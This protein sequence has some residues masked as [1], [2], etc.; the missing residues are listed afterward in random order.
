MHHLYLQSKHASLVITTY[1][2]R[3]LQSEH[4]LFATS[5][6]INRIYN[7]NM[8]R[9]NNNIR[10]LYFQSEHVEFVIPSYINCILKQSIFIFSTVCCNLIAVAVTPTKSQTL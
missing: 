8:L 10:Q 3:V 4:V 7:R 6:Y 5:T 2:N 1:I 9:I